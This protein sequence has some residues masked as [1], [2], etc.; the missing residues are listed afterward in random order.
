M[1]L[2]AAALPARAAGDW[3]IARL[4]ETLARTKASEA[5]FVERKYIA[6]LDAPLESSGELSYV[7]PDRLEKRTLT[8]KPES[9][10]L[11]GD[12]LT[13]ERGGRKRSLPLSAYPEIGALVDS[14]RGTLAG[15]HQALARSY[16]LAL[17][18]DAAH[19]TLT[20]TPSEPR[21]AQYVQKIRI[22]GSRGEVTMVEVFQA[23]GDRSLMNIER[24]A[25]SRNAE[26]AP[27]S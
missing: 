3:D 17:E 27:A 9:M 4:M 18:G 10:L 6:L 19:W 1:L 26:K 7:A 24:S 25:R 11:D 5:K 13:L 12:T 2:L 22:G 14:I 15:D 21:M 23:D 16:A 20:L 8:P